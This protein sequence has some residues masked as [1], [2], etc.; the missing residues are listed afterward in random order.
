MVQLYNPPN[1]PKSSSAYVAIPML[2]I[3]PGLQSADSDLLDSGES[4]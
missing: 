4:K 2:L 3:K 1:R